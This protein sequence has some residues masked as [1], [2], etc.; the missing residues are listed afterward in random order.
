ML[1]LDLDIVLLC[2]LVSLTETSLEIKFEM[3]G[4]IA[5]MLEMCYDIGSRIVM[6]LAIQG[7]CLLIFSLVPAFR[8]WGEKRRTFQCGHCSASCEIGTH[9]DEK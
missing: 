9:E 7:S 1:E 8:F 3:K 6:A 4:E 5:M 2:V